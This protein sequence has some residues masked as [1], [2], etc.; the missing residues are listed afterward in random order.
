MIFE[1]GFFLIEKTELAQEFGVFEQNS[2]FG[3]LCSIAGSA[4]S[5]IGDL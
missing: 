4:S 5:I 3:S 1:T 2:E